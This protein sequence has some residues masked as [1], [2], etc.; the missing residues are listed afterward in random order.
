MASFSTIQKVILLGVIVASVPVLGFNMLLPRLAIA[1]SS[2]LTLK[3]VDIT[4]ENFTSFGNHAN[5][6]TLDLWLQVGLPVKNSSETS[7]IS[8]GSDGKPNVTWDT[9]YYNKDGSVNKDNLVDPTQNVIVPQLDLTATYQGAV[10]GTG[11]SV[12]IYQLNVSHPVEYAHIYLN[13]SR[14][15]DGGLMFMFNGITTAG[16]LDDIIQ[17]LLLGS[18]GDAGSALLKELN[19]TITAYAGSAPLT[20]PLPPS[21]LG[22]TPYTL[23]LPQGVASDAI[24]PADD[25][26]SFIH[27]N[28]KMNLVKL[29]GTMSRFASQLGFSSGNTLAIVL[30]LLGLGTTL[31]MTALLGNT[32]LITKFVN[33][34]DMLVSM[35]QLPKVNNYTLTTNDTWWVE[36]NHTIYNGLAYNATQMYGSLAT[37]L[38]TDFPTFTIPAGK[39]NKSTL[40]TAMLAFIGGNSGELNTWNTNYVNNHNSWYWRLFENSSLITTKVL[41]SMGQYY[42]YIQS[43]PAFA[44]FLSVVAGFIKDTPLLGTIVNKKMGTLNVTGMP[45]LANLFELFHY[46]NY[47]LGDL[48]HA[49]GLTVPQVITSIFFSNA[50]ICTRIMSNVTNYGLETNAYNPKFGGVAAIG[51]TSVSPRFGSIDSTSILLVIVILAF[52][53]VFLLLSIT[54]GTVKINRREFLGREDVQR[55][56]N[57]FIKQVE[58]LGGKVSVQNAESLVIRAFRLQGKI[59]KAP[60]VERRAKT[61][62]ENQ[63]LLVTLQSRASRAYVA[64][65]FKD[66]IAAIEKMIDIARKLEDQTLVANYEDNLAKVVKLLRRKGISV[67]TKVRVD[68]G[69]QAGSEVEKLSAYKKDLI[70]LQNKASKLFAERNWAEAKNCIKE[71][72][73]IAKKIQD[74]VLIRNYEANLRKIISM[75]KGGN[76]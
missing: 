51:S 57:A 28:H 15:A 67:S 73:A 32:S 58:Q 54:K 38:S 40:D 23:I 9:S 31:D 33:A 18:G 49:L 53:V 8:R 59:E 29:G 34:V 21:I 11:G 60:D 63:K 47:T 12:N 70:D 27:Y 61:Y 42:N 26:G 30:Q 6:A 64:Q 71:M 25:I 5:T 7:V 50:T 72:L 10:V 68:E 66:C 17:G 74:P 14:E 16:T 37:D 45:S 76:A 46:N 41:V 69:A 44:A 22:G 20:M 4:V 2:K 62:V 35:D 3:L 13:C 55:N 19:M 65:K 24:S 36:A 75:E 48:F 52:L 39:Y 56:I 43:T 1:D